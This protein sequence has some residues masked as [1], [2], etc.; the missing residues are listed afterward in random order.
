MAELSSQ[1]AAISPGMDVETAQKG[2]VSIMKAFGKTTDEVESGIMDKINYLGN[3]FAETNEDIVQGLMRSSAAMSAVGESFENTAALFT[4]GM[5]ILQNAE[6]MGTAL[7][8]FSLRIRGYSE[9]SADGADGWRRASRDR[10]RRRSACLRAWL[11][12]WSSP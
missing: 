9:E 6:K 2:L 1:F 11:R 7:R 4:G 12:R 10:C 3:H 8:S 5:E